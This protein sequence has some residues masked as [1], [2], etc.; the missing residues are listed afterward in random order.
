[1]NLQVRYGLEVAEDEL[2]DS[3][4]RDVRPIQAAVV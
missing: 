1:M 2:A 4:A 3:I